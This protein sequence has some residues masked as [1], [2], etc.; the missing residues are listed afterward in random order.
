M[1]RCCRVKHRILLP[2]CA[3]VGI[4]GDMDRGGVSASPAGTMQWLDPDGRAH[5]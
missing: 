4:V 2:S 1:I 5:F 3:P